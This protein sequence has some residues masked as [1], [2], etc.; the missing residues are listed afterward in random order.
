M[1]KWLCY[2]GETSQS[3]LKRIITKWVYLTLY[4]QLCKNKREIFNEITCTSQVKNKYVKCIYVRIAIKYVESKNH[5]SVATIELWARA[6]DLHLGIAGRRWKSVRVRHWKVGGLG[7]LSDTA[8]FSA[9]QHRETVSN[10]VGLFALFHLTFRTIGL[11]LHT[12]VAQ[13][14]LP[15]NFQGDRYHLYLQLGAPVGSGS[16]KLKQIWIPRSKK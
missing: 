1:P 9:D 5:S 12:F 7:V 14:G 6:E 4:F 15:L 10:N 16:P 3:I 2:V 13:Q 11:H 8:F